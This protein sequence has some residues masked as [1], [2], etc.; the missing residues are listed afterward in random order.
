[1]PPSICAWREGIW[2]CPAWMHLSERDL[3]D[4][5]GSDSG[6]LEGAGDRDA[7]EFSCVDRSEAATHLAEGCPCG[8]KNH[9]AGHLPPFMIWLRSLD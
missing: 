1:M 5:F 3:L 8:R 2:P 7:S 4:L 6:T 9:C